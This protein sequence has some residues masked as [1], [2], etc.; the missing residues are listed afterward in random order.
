MDFT[1]SD[2]AFTKLTTLTAVTTPQ[3]LYA[4]W[5]QEL[6][7]SSIGSDADNLDSDDKGFLVRAPSGNP[8]RPLSEANRLGFSSEGMIEIY[9]DIP[10]DTATSVSINIP[11]TNRMY[12]TKANVPRMA[13]SFHPTGVDLASIGVKV[14]L[15]PQY[16][17]MQGLLQRGGSQS[18]DFAAKFKYREGFQIALK[19]ENGSASVPIYVM[20]IGA[21]NA[22]ITNQQLLITIKQSDTSTLIIDGD[23][24][25][26]TLSGTVIDESGHPA[27]RKIRVYDRLTGNLLA[28][29]TSKSDG[30]YS[31]PAVI[32]GEMYAVALDDDTP[33][34]LNAL[35]FDRITLD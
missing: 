25:Y 28:E 9:K 33:P 6:N 2:G 34:S 4:Q 10:S 20:E 5:C 16:M 27:Q 3:N 29:T 1:T 12:T 24:R 31:L 21:D 18:V 17:L 7:V 13:I 8:I 30:T 14:R 22:T 23:Y 35:I 11:N 26:G 15:T 19:T 32:N